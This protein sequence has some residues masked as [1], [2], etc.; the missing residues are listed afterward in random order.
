MEKAFGEKFLNK[1]GDS[2]NERLVRI[3]L[4]IT[5]PRMVTYLQKFVVKNHLE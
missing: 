2:K 3:F 1:F 5:L 4:N